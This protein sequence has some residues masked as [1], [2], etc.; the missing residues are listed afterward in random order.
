MT[1][2]QKLKKILSDH[3]LWLN[4]NGGLKAN[5]QYADLQYADLRYA[6]LR[7]ADL[8][9]ANLQGAN[10]RY[11]DLR[12]ADLRSADLQYANLQGANL[13]GANL[14]GANL[15]GANLRK[16][17]LQYANL[18]GADLDFSC[19]PLWCGSRDIKCNMR[20]IYQLLAHIYVL[21]CD[22]KEFSEIKDL[23]LPY[24]R[25]SHRANELNISN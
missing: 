5:L 16:A 22:D 11:A 12:Y 23:I 4:N 18:Q 21:T 7:S 25:K 9:K 1:E 2:E 10:L 20:L 13:Q 17:D 3:K 15:Q 14:Q 24:A 6:D 8:R 19:F